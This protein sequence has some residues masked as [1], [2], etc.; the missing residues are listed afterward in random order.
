[1]S[2]WETEY[3]PDE[4]KGKKKSMASDFQDE[5]TSLALDMQQHLAARGADDPDMDEIAGDAART[6]PA[7]ITPRSPRPAARADGKAG[8]GRRHERGVARRS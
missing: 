3:D 8:Q 4:K 2:F 1:M 7:S 6:R 5:L